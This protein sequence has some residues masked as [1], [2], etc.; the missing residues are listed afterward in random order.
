VILTRLKEYADTQMDL[1]PEMY[2]ATPVRWLINLTLAGQRDGPPTPLGG[3]TKNNKRGENLLIP[4]L[5]RASGIKPKLLADNGEYVLGIGRADGDSAKVAERH[6]QFK[7]LVQQCAQITQEASV[8]AIVNFLEQWIPDSSLFPKGFDPQDTITFRVDDVLPAVEI[9]SVQRFWARH[10]AGQ[11]EENTGGDETTP[12]TILQ[13]LVTK[14]EGPVEARMPGKIK[15]I[16]GGQTSGTSL[17]SANATAFSHY[18]LENSLTSP[19]SRDAAER[20]TKALNHLISLE[21]SRLYVGP[22]LYVFWTREKSVFNPRKPLAQPR[23]GEIKHM[24]SSI[25]TGAEAYGQRKNAF[26]ALALSASGGRAVVRNW[27][28][29]TVPDAARNLERWFRAQNIVD[30]YGQTHDPLGVKQLA[31]SLY[32]RS[33]KIRKFDAS[34]EIPARVISH[35]VGIALQGGPIS[36]EWLAQVVR[37][38]AVGTVIQNG[39]REHVTRAQAAFIKLALSTQPGGEKH[40]DDLEKFT[41]KPNL[42]R[43]DGIAYQCGCLLAELEAIQRAA[44]G[45]VNASIVERYY[46]AA[47]STPSMAFAS[48]L[49]GARAHLGKLRNQKRGTWNALEQELEKILEPFKQNE[50]DTPRF[51]KTLSIVQQG[52][53]ALGFY[54]RR[55]ENRAQIDAR[56]NQTSAPTQISTGVKP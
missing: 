27:L 26:Y 3:D 39:S 31:E 10:T 5:V 23:A 20:F 11:P 37:R 53:F 40:M 28:E 34:K 2:T 12:R 17:V 15:G 43:D 52:I 13:C 22:V 45:K 42:E 36:S 33:Y 32:R 38:C 7:E 9:E 47:S 30:D 51:P 35:L 55:A 18:A 41:P 1:P 6:R 54:H 4:N 16:P 44:L 29:I 49:K 21:D 46:G 8:Q 56:R 48:L 25:Y 14:T 50:D 19:I 24:L